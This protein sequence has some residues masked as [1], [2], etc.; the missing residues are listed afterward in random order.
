[1]CTIGWC[2]LSSLRSTLRTSILRAGASIE[3]AAAAAR[4]ELVGSSDEAQ[5]RRQRQYA[6]QT[7]ADK[8]ATFTRSLQRTRSLLNDEIARSTSA[9]STLTSST[10]V[11]GDTS[12]EYDSYG[13][14]VKIGS[15]I[16]TKQLQRERTD[17]L[18]ILVGLCFFT[19]VVCYILNRRLSPF[20]LWWTTFFV[21]KAPTATQPTNHHQ[22]HQHQPAVT[23]STSTTGGH[24]TGG[25]TNVVYH[26]PMSVPTPAGTG[27]VAYTPIA[28]VAA[29]HS[30]HTGAVETSYPMYAPPR[31]T[32]PEHDVTGHHHHPHQ[33]QQ[34]PEATLA[35]ADRQR[36]F[37][38]QQEA[39]RQR[40]L[41]YVAHTQVPHNQLNTP[42]P[43][44]SVHLHS[45]AYQRQQDQA[46]ELARHHGIESN[47]PHAPQTHQPAG[48]PAGHTP[49]APPPPHPGAGDAS[50]AHAPPS[51]TQP[52]DMQGIHA[53][54]E[55]P[56]QHEHGH[57]HGH[58]HAH[59]EL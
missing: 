47:Q 29:P 5:V 3:R 36:I 10:R 53:F 8:N 50:H 13:K 15:K 26:A 57:G 39:E 4:L 18:L 34:Q 40:Q 25:L 33:Q 51:R 12:G 37:L 58:A 42:Q 19:L 31:L 1:M 49:S 32:T 46:A 45:P 27:E 55:P 35:Y 56:H 28:P 6:E 20:L 44:A 30:P 7:A 14:T 16:I 48:S 23:S 22:L 38:Q 54:D 52:P 11:L 21:A 43:G 2:G 41:Q 59:D 9:L 24:P 17:K